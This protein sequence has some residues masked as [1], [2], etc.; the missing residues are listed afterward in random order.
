MTFVITIGR[1][2]IEVCRGGGRGGGGVRADRLSTL[3]ALCRV[4]IHKYLSSSLCGCH[5]IGPP[6]D[7]LRSHTSRKLFNGLP[8]FLLPFGL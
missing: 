2:I 4:P 3:L 1:P 8:W 7:P 6:V 5:G